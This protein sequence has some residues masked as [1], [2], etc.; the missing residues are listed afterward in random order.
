[1]T[2]TALRR[3]ENL[4]PSL[5]G[6]E[7]INRYRD[8]QHDVVAAKI[9][10]GEYYVTQ[11]DEMI[12]TVLGSCISACIRDPVARIGG[13]NHFMLPVATEEN[14]NRWGDSYLSAATRYGNYAMEH[15][16]NDILKYGGRRERL[17]VKITGGGRVLA[18]MTDVGLR[19]IQFVDEYVRTESLNLPR[20]VQYF[21]LS[22]RA[23]VKKII[24]MHNNTIIERENNYLHSLEQ[25]PVAGEV[26]LF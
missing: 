7:A 17:E 4:L 5:P 22:G 15:M 20:K 14:K 25:K 21:P 18:Q 16:I 8:H 26:E 23:R 19:N 24:S 1:M 13:M 6:F 10:P 3:K 12:V 2:V 9:L 11:Q